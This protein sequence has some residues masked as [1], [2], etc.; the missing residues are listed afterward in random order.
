MPILPHGD[1]TPE[2]PAKI[3]LFYCEGL[4]S[5]LVFGPLIDR[6][7]DL[8]SAVIR[9]PIIPKSIKTKKT[10]TKL[11]SN[12]NKSALPFKLYNV[13]VLY[14]YALIAFFGRGRLVAKCR[15]AGVLHMDISILDEKARTKIA[16]LNPDYIF[17]DSAIILTKKVLS[18][19]Q[20]GVVNF[21]AAPLPEY[22]GA[23]NYFWLLRNEEQSAKGTLHFVDS[24]LDTGPVIDFTEPVVIEPGMSV[25]SLW[26][27]MRLASRPAIEKLIDTIRQNGTPVSTPQQAEY[28]TVRTFPTAD[29]IRD[30]RKKGHPIVTLHNL[31]QLVKV[32]L[33]G[34]D[35]SNP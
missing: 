31:M 22:R 35:P 12:L 3:V 5:Y 15:K 21:H 13:L 9:F 11:S 24:G 33:S 6:H 20:F 7:A 28:A 14:V 25:M 34:S 19:A 17:N 8:I 16:R 2:K 30:I 26:I 27:K 10:P 23:G 1:E 18:L 32:A 4:S 29:V